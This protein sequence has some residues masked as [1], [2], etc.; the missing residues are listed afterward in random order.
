MIKG[1][2]G[3]ILKFSTQDPMSH[4][5]IVQWTLN[6]IPPILKFEMALNVDPEPVLAV[7]EYYHFTHP[8][9]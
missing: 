8:H 1:S 2:H 4:I 9:A 5:R 6:I 7:M 3:S